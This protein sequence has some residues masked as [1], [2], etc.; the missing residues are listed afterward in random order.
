MLAFSLLIPA[1][2]LPCTPPLL[3]VRLRRAWYAPL[4]RILSYAAAASV[5][6]LS[7]GYFRRRD[8]RPVS[9]YALFK[10]WLLLSQHPGCFRS[11][12]SFGENQLSPRSIGISPLCT[13]H[14]K[15]FQHSRVRPSAQFYLS[16]SLAMHRSLWFRVYP[17]E[18]FALLRLA[19]ASAPRFPLNLARQ[20]NSPVHSSIGTPSR[21]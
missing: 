15:V 10:W 16:F 17:V 11:P 8:S 14:P 4:P 5:L 2:S 3:P 7:P 19:F 20:D 9:Y 18:L 21:I 1:F 12:T 13:A 6:Y